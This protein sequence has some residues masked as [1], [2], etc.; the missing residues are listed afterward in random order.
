MQLLLAEV[1]KTEFKTVITMTSWL[2]IN[3]ESSRKKKK[4]K[5]IK[6]GHTEEIKSNREYLLWKP[7]YII[8]WVFHSRKKKRKHNKEKNHMVPE[9]KNE[10]N[11]QVSFSLLGMHIHEHVIV[12]IPFFSLRTWNDGKIVEFKLFVFSEITFYFI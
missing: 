11:T 3:Y 12:S 2:K 10:E 8:G 7:V 1:K 9:Y 4:K 6:F 5:V